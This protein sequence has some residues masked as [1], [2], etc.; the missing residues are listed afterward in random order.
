MSLFA[1][2]QPLVMTLE[3]Y[4]AMYGEDDPEEL[5]LMQIKDRAFGDTV[6]EVLGDLFGLEQEDFGEPREGQ[7]NQYN[8]GEVE[9]LHELREIG[10]ASQGREAVEYQDGR[11]PV[12]ALMNHLINHDDGGGYYLPVPFMQSFFV[13]E[14]SVGSAPGLLDDLSA[15]EEPLG[16]RYPQAMERARALLQG[17]AELP[18]EAPKP[19]AGP[20]W[21]WL[22]LTRLCREAV[23]RNLPVHF[24]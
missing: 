3:G 23:E 2:V 18:E 21:T 12:G 6:S 19:L 11:A 8:I 4:R 20:V 16:T 9:W 14:R 13:D 17:E 1:A 24:G 10:A 5:N 15:L 7:G 22:T